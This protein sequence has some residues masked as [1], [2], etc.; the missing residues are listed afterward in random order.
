MNYYFA[1]MEGITGHL[2]RSL[3]AKMFP[4]MT[5]YY[6]PFVTPRSKKSLTTRDSNDVHPENNVGLTL[7]PQILTNSTEG[8]LETAEAFQ[9]LG[10]TEVNLNLG[11]PSGTVVSKGRGSGFLAF[12]PELERFLEE[13]YAKCPISISVKTRI[14][15]DYEEEWQELMPIF[16]RFPIEKLIIHPRLRS[17]YYKNHPHMDVFRD[18]LRQ[19][20]N[21][22][23]YNGDLYTPADVKRF[24]EE[25]PQLD[26][27]MIGRGLII[28]PALV[29][30][31][32]GG[33]PLE[34][35]ELKE[36]H[37]SILAAYQKVMPGDRAGLF[38]M[39]ELWNYWGQLFPDAQKPLKQ[40][41]K[42]QRFSDYEAGVAGVF[43]CELE[44]RNDSN[45]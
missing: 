2:Y 26:T 5:A 42:A 10:Y 27:V 36:F 11:C 15:M 6:A 13:I 20:V 14:G 3:H 39:K 30:Q 23:I 8:F 32:Q 18:A 43:R 17:D 22:V 29:R 31:C 37:D 16:N 7:V 44:I 1:P 45:S 12:Q 34:K 38:K 41:R 9:E 40:I 28:N 33:R 25:F 35:T 4:G 21:P 19:S 24:S